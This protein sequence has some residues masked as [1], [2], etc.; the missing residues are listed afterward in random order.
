M[1]ID[2]PVLRLYNTL[3]RQKQTF[4]P[5]D[6]QN[7]RLYVC[8]P[9]VYDYAHIGNARPI[10]VF[11]ML[12][13]MLRYMYGEHH[14]TYA[15]N[16]TDVD[17]KI[18]AKAAEEGVSID[19]VTDRTTV[20]FHSDIAALGVLSPTIEPRATDHIADM[21]SMIDNLIARGFAY[22]ADNHVLFDTTAMRDYGALS[23]RPLDEM[24][25]G[26]RVE[27]AS[28]KR[29]P[30]DFVLWKPSSSG[31]PAWASPGGVEI[32][33]RPGWHIECSAMAAKHLGE[34][35]DIH[36]GGIDLVFP[37][38][39]NEV[40]QSRCVHGTDIMANIWLHNGFV[41]VEGQKMSKSLGNFITIYDLLETPAFGG[42]AWSGYV[43]RLAMLM[44]HYREPIDWT[45][46][47]LEEAEAKLKRWKRALTST[48][49]RSEPV[50]LEPLYEALSDDLATPKAIQVLDN[51]AR[52]NDKAA[53]LA[54]GLCF[55]GFDLATF[56]EV[57]LETHT[58][59]EELI[60]ERGQALSDKNWVKADQIRAKLLEEGI[61]LQDFRDP[62]TGA[63]NTKW[64]CL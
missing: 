64:E 3:T 21:R 26:A 62:E 55:L 6:R 4:T 36:G 35:F 38:H 31:T 39:E 48:D 29:N 61:Q 16:I 59:I 58:Y 11:D 24:I 12:F 1:M 5:I 33:G 42:R 52:S 18:N 2:Q 60:A 20:Q 14:V 50:Q 15:R 53:S 41:Q 25:A 47:R 27:I 51:M 57:D 13:R 56:G 40:A 22:V 44:T 34:T 23:Q 19:V 28:Y 43:L 7:V 30:T 10:I 49:A 46:R 9:T 8:G 37:H 17:D 45:V 32:P 54:A 63:R